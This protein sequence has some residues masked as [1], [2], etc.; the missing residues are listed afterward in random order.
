M[1]RP[2]GPAQYLFGVMTALDQLANALL[3][4][5]SHW[6]ISARTWVAYTKGKGWA[7]WARP[8]IDALMRQRD[9]CRLAYEKYLT[10]IRLDAKD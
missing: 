9:H 6:T 5:D 1:T 8:R 10:L 4:G 3:A 7:L 2:K